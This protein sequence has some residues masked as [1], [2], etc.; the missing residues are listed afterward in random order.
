MKKL[1]I[2][3][4]FLTACNSCILI[5]SGPQPVDCNQLG[6]DLHRYFINEQ[7]RV[8]YGPP[9]LEQA[10]M[11]S[12]WPGEPRTGLIVYYYKCKNP[13]CKKL[14]RIFSQPRDGLIMGW[15][16]GDCPRG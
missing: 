6:T 10:E 16:T 13:N 1:F 4:S 3:I 8:K 5:E 9:E 7:I 15:E 11:V 12:L 14:F 2:L